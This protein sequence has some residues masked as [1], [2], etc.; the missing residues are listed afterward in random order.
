VKLNLVVDDI[1]KQPLEELEAIK[2]ALD[3]RYEYI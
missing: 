3:A 1:C 2:E